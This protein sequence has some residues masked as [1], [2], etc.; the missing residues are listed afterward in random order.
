M[1][2]IGLAH[3]NRIADTG[4]H[5]YTGAGLCVKSYRGLGVNKSR[6]APRTF[7]MGLQIR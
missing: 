7:R 1:R 4:A 2:F 6:L 3:C 5:R